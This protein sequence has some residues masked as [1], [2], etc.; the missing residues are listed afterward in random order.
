MSKRVSYR[1]GRTINMGD[2]ESVKFEVG[3]ESDVDDVAT[4]KKVLSELQDFVEEVVED[5]TRR[6]KK[7]R[8]KKMGTK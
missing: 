1:L 2:F 5:E 7:V 6:W 4:E 3:M 8:R